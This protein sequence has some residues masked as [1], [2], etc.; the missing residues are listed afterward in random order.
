MLGHSLT[1]HL[2][3]F[4]FSVNGD[5]PSPAPADSASS[6]GT[7]VVSGEPALP[8]DRTSA[9]VGGPPVQET[10][11]SSE[12]NECIVS[13]SAAFGSEAQSTLD[14][15]ISNSASSSAF[16]AAKLRQPDGCMEPVRQQS[17]STNTETLPS[18]YVIF[19]FKHG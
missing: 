14:P 1:D 10:L 6:T 9:P 15:S 19:F 2:A 13:N 12:N 7:A 18:G 8:S 3:A 5:P 4:P 16:D 11:T 17:G